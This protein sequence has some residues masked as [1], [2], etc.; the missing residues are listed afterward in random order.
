MASQRVGRDLWLN[1]ND[2]TNVLGLLL[3]GFVSMGKLLSFSGL[4]FLLCNMWVRVG[5]ARCEGGFSELIMYR[6]HLSIW[7]DT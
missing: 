2:K 7:A 3:T 5:F 1:T 4:S 6:Q